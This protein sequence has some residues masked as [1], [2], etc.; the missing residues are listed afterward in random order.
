VRHESAAFNAIIA[1]I[2]G[3]RS[4]NDIALQLGAGPDVNLG[5]MKDAVRLCLQTLH[6]SLEPA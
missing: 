3:Q 5:A 1:L 2:D 4:I 6:P